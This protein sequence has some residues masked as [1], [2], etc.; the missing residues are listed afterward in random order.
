MKSKESNRMNAVFRAINRVAF[1]IVIILTCLQH[2]ASVSA[3]TPLSIPSESLSKFCKRT[4]ESVK[5][6]ISLHA[7]KEAS[8]EAFIESYATIA[9][10]VERLSD[11]NCIVS[12]TKSHTIDVALSP[13][14]L[15]T[16]DDLVY[17]LSAPGYLHFAAIPGPLLPI[18]A[19]I[20]QLSTHS[21]EVTAEATPDRAIKILATHDNVREAFI[22]GGPEGTIGL[23]ITLDD[24]GQAAVEYFSINSSGEH[25]YVV[26]DG[27]VVLSS[28]IDEPLLMHTFFIPG[29]DINQDPVLDN[30][31]FLL[32]TGTLPI[33]F[34]ADR[35]PTA[36]SC[37]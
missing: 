36:S 14:G 8:P 12:V 13:V 10:R 24:R 32:E 18:G 27:I 22:C 33:Q 7:G 26:L 3:S 4:D 21:S 31:A 37:P 25:L 20:A 16:F 23:C 1:S 2:T 5:V 11:G 34:K 9:R 6:K 29:P 17:L 19:P 28:Q 35:A 15:L 30:V